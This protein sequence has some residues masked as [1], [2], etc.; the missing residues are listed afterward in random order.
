MNALVTGGAGFIGRWAVKALLDKKINVYALDNLSNGRKENLDEFKA[1][2]NFKGL[3]VGDI[4]DKK[5][6][7]EIFKNK[8]DVC[9]HLAASI[10]IHDSII[11]PE[12]TVQNNI[13][14]TLN[15]LEE[16]RKNKTKVVFM[17]SAH[18]YSEAKGRA[19]NEEHPTK[20]SSPYSASKIA[21]E[22]LALSYWNAYG[23]PVAIVR[24]FTAYGPYQ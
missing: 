9:L 14:G 11:D 18:V 17:S 23:L 5:I 12:A 24:T 10:N 19:I 3:V 8:I 21:G 22:N 7:A 20:A 6:L 2:A 13:V 1:N 4:K 16:A 15:V